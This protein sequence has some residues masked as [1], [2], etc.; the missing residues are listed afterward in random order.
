M[1][2]LDI[3]FEANDLTKKQANQ[4]KQHLDAWPGSIR[5]RPDFGINAFVEVPGWYEIKAITKNNTSAYHAKRMSRKGSPKPC[6]LIVR[7]KDGKVID[8]LPMANSDLKIRYKRLAEGDTV[9]LSPP[10]FTNIL[11]VT[12]CA[13]PARKKPART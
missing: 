9:T 5:I 4:I 6:I 12:S 8:R 3:V 13:N 10:I 7:N 2:L 11:T 1:K